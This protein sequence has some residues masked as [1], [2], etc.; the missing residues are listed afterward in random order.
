MF[1]VCIHLQWLKY[2]FNTSWK[3]CWTG[4]KEIEPLFHFYLFFL[5]K[6][7]E[8][9]NF[10]SMLSMTLYPLVLNNCTFNHRMVVILRRYQSAEHAKESIIQSLWQGRIGNL[11]M[12]HRQ[13]RFLINVIK[14]GKV[15]FE[16]RYDRVTDTLLLSWCAKLPC[17]NGYWKQITGKR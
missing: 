3:S 5:F 17:K 14:E 4:N 10:T 16:I 2:S 15:W 12:V 9:F 7:Y 8:W 11:A 6:W 13:R 1:K